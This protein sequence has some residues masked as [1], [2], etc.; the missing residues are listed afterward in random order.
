MAE[1]RC[2]GTESMDWLD[3]DM[4]EWLDLAMGR[5]TISLAVRGPVEVV[6]LAETSP[7][8]DGESRA[9]DAQQYS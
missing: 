7:Q 9:N 6:T 2:E 3:A 4:R 8:Q 1:K 5:T